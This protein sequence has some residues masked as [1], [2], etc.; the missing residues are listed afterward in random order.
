MLRGCS[1]IKKW[2][3]L[4][5]VVLGALWQVYQRLNY[6]ICC[7][8]MC[9]RLFVDVCVCVFVYSLMCV[10]VTFFQIDN[11]LGRSSKYEVCESHRSGMTLF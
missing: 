2:E 11:N 9:V 8:C 7:V 1:Q 4:D 3:L 5:N 10:Y 6:F